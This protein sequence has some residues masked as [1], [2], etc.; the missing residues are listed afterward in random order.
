MEEIIF[1]VTLGIFTGIGFIVIGVKIQE[2]MHKFEDYFEAFNSMD[3]KISK[4][5]KRVKKLENTD[6]FGLKVV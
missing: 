5:E 2:I 6:E 3:F 4:I 1:F